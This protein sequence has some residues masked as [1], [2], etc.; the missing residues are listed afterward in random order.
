MNGQHDNCPVPNELIGQLYRASARTIHE[1][2]SHLS[3]EDRGDLAA[4]CYARAHLRGIGVAVAATCS[5]QTLMDAA[6]RAG[7]VLFDLSRQ[8]WTEEKAVPSA[9]AG[10]ISLAAPMAAELSAR[11]ARRV[12]NESRF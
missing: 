1:L 8:Q 3:A 9:R 4:F 10:R 6:G 12:T 11:P 7:A 2:V 5:L